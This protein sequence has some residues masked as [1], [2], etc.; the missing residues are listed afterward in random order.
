MLIVNMWLLGKG[1]FATESGRGERAWILA[2]TVI[3]TVECALITGAL[4]TS[5]SSRRRGFALSIASCSGVVIIGAGIFG[6]LNL[7]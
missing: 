3:T 1:P 4:L 6:Y 7:R 2:A 5:S